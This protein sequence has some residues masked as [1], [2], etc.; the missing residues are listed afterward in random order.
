[1]FAGLGQVHVPTVN[2]E[3]DPLLFLQLLSKH[4][5]SRTF[6]PSSF[7]YRLQCIL[8]TA[9]PEEIRGVDLGGLVYIGSDGEANNVE[10]C[11][12]ISDI[13]ARLRAKNKMGN[14]LN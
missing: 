3:T 4:N 14:M 10:N 12:R 6:A 1:M 2:V 7:L 8:D 9:S 13:L 5:V 11:V